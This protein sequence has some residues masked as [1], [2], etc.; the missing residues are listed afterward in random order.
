MHILNLDLRACDQS[1]QSRKAR[2]NLKKQNWEQLYDSDEINYFI[3]MFNQY[4]IQY[5]T[6]MFCVGSLCFYDFCSSV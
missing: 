5:H 4:F 3:N 6:Y 2:L 1:I